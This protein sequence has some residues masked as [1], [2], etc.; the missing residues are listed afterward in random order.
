MIGLELKKKNPLTIKE[1]L[2]EDVIEIIY[3]DKFKKS[4][5]PE[6]KRDNI[7]NTN[8]TLNAMMKIHGQNNTQLL[9]QR[10]KSKIQS[11][12]QQSIKILQ[13]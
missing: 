5:S 1:Q 2:R 4:R 11:K 6:S 3:S 7:I 10:K 9:M 13:K 12:K 8:E